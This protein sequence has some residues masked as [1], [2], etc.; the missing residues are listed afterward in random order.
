MKIIAITGSI[1]CGKTYLANMIR[2]LGY[3]VYDADKWVK[4]L[5]Y[6]K[7]FL[8]EIKKVFPKVFDENGVF[9]KRNLRNIVFNDNKELKKLESLIHP[10]LKNKL[11]QKINQLA[12]KEKF[13]FID[14]ALLFEMKW[15]NYCDY[16]ILADV[17]KNIQKQRVMKR[18]NITEDDFNKIINVQIDNNLKKCMSDLIIDTAQTDGIVKTQLINF[19]E[20]IS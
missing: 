13:M 6:K 4:Y 11:K 8:A 1:G 19:I 15:D 10:F 2:S 16:I 7:E 5:Y 17:D 12:S 14:V 20:G 3:A 18:D 9:N